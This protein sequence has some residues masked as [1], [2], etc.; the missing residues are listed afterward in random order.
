MKL[1]A[2]HWIKYQGEWH[3][4]GEVFTIYKGD[5]EEMKAHGEII[6]EEEDETGE[7]PE[8]TSEDAQEEPVRRARRRKAEAIA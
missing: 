8:G 6:R 2:N 3:R 4:A 1:K 7:T 5:A